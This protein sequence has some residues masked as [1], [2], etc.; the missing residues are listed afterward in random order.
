MTFPCSSSPPQRPT[1][2]TLTL[3]RTNPKPLQS[4]FLRHLDPSSASSTKPSTL[5]YRKPYSSCFYSA[6]H[7]FSRLPPRDAQR[8][9]ALTISV[10]ANP[11][12][13]LS[14]SNTF[15][16]SQFARARKSLLPCLFLRLPNTSRHTPLRY[17]RQQFESNAQ[18][19]QL[20]PGE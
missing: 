8:H 17:L 3:R 16:R 2:A 19:M 12:S 4:P 6:T 10:C 14:Q 9:P 13:L 15:N 5:R 11:P 1:S 20:N 18:T 7:A